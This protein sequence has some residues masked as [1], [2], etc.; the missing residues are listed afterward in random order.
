MASVNEIYDLVK[1]IHR[2]PEDLGY[3]DLS[4]RI[5]WFKDYE[6]TT[7]KLSTLDLDEW[8]VDEEYVE[9]YMKE[10]RSS[11]ETMP[12]IIYD[13]LAQSIIDGTHRANACFNLGLEDIVAYVGKTKSNDYGLFEDN[14]EE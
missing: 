11:K 7:I 12:P 9:D 3:G 1:K 14:D 6:L 10:I 4:D 13:P 2:K 8:D 5:F